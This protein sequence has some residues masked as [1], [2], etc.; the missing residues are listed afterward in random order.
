[1]TYR[2]LLF[3]SAF[4]FFTSTILGQV[5]I[6]SGDAPQ[7]F[8]VLELI[9]S[10]QSPKGLRLPHLSS[11]D[12][13]DLD[14]ASLT[15]PAKSKAIGLMIY[16]TDDSVIEYWDGSKW[17]R[18]RQVAPWLISGSS[19]IAT[20]NTQNIYQTG[21][22]SIGSPSSSDPSAMLNI[23]SADKGVLIP[24]V[25]LNS[26]TDKA[27]INGNNPTEGLL[28]YNMGTDPAFPLSGFMYWNGE[29]WKILVMTDAVEPE[30]SNLYCD[31]AV[32]TPST[33][34]QGVAYKGILEV[35]YD[36][37]NGGSYEIGTL[38]S[39][40]SGMNGLTVQLQPGTLGR[41]AGKLVY[42]V[43]G[44]PTASSPQTSTLPVSFTDKNTTHS[45]QAV[46]G[47]ANARIENRDP[48]LSGCN[49][50]GRR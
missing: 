6:G 29:E 12:I 4:I 21:Q 19:N 3:F 15:E 13:I 48:Y 45:C 20:L 26:R 46:V 43:T 41:G 39:G 14:L 32:L 8:S 31:A 16:N 10:S 33:Y 25:A 42:A 22:V 50:N 37:G 7:D 47:I 28:V 1:M 49:D 38:I 44:T 36:G 35:P 27:S 18:A 17:V 5:T 2:L 23:T 11:Q 9:S 40:V 30:I 34:Q 24:R